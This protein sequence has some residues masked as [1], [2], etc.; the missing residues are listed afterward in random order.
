MSLVF[1]SVQFFTS[2]TFVKKDFIF[3]FFLDNSPFVSISFTNSVVFH[4]SITN[5]LMNNFFLP[6]SFSNSFFSQ[7][8]SNSVFFF[9]HSKVF[10]QN[11]SNFISSV[12][13]SAPRFLISRFLR[14]SSMITTSL[15]PDYYSSLIPS[16]YLSN[17]SFETQAF[18][19]FFLLIFLV[20]F[21][22]FLFFKLKS[23]RFFHIP[24]ASNSKS[25]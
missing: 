22:R 18:K 24:Y 4:K 23:N 21:N 3:K 7:S 9:S 11:F 5:I 12:Y 20:K 19:N 16:F 13:S 1:A 10:S 14:N 2:S 6:F 25:K 15:L 17:T 8:L